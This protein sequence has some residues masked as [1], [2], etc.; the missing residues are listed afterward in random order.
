MSRSLIL[1]ACFVAFGCGSEA[2]SSEDQTPSAPVTGTIDGKLFAG[3]VALASYSPLSRNASITIYDE[4]RTCDDLS[5][6]MEKR[7]W[8]VFVVVRWQSGVIGELPG[9]MTLDGEQISDRDFSRATFSRPVSMETLADETESIEVTSGHVEVIEAS[10][11]EGSE[12][13]IRLRAVAGAHQVEG[14]IA[15][16]LCRVWS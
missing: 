10:P 8:S 12:G 4:P 14:E 15:V 9:A 11:K 1:L 13:R 2:A 7:G 16:T 3:K 5:G 6:P